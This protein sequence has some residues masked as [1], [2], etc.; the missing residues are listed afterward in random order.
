ML[1]EIDYRDKRPL[2][3]QISGKIEELILCGVISADEAL[4]SVRSLAMDLSINPNTIQKAYDAL[5]QRGLCY[6]VTGR[7][8]FAA[9][10][11]EVLPAKKREILDELDAVVDKAAKIGMTSAELIDRVSKKMTT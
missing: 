10:A 1:I 9:S 6:S 11:D 3:E 7:G 2:Y 5:E 8:R 4:P